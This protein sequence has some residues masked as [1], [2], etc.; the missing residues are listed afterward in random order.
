MEPAS[1]GSKDTVIRLDNADELRCNNLLWLEV[2]DWS[3]W[4]ERSVAG[5]V[6]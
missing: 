1:S 4:I 5:V 2:V 3:T 6:L